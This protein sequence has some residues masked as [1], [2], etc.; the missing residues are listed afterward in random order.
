MQ[1]KYY[2]FRSRK[3]VYIICTY[4]CCRVECPYN[5]PHPSAF[6]LV[7]SSTVIPKIKM[8]SFPI[9]SC[10]STLAPSRVPIVRAPLACV[11]VVRVY[12]CVC[13]CV[14]GV[15]V[16]GTCVC[17]CVCGVCVWNVCVCGTWC[18]RVCVCIYAAKMKQLQLYEYHEFHVS[19]SGS[20]CSSSGDL[21]KRYK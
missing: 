16:C 18:A 1:P 9:S 2:A 12:V 8:F 5:N 4:V 20:F 13:T 17:A 7:T 15:C 19:S 14:C 3:A 21:Q 10:I 6:S 11:C